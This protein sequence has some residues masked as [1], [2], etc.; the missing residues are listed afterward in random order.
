MP[1]TATIKTELQSR[2]EEL[3]SRVQKIEG[4]LRAEHSA[5]FSEQ[6]AERED[7]EVM[8]RLEIDALNEIV[9]IKAAMDRIDADTYGICTSCGNDID[10]KR[11]EILPYAG[12]CVSCAK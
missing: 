3:E 2:L 1:D 12:C 5:N 8:E 4:T 9:A 11:L 7:E 6:A 10:E